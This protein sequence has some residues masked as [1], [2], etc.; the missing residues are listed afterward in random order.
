LL[1]LNINVYG[2]S[3]KLVYIFTDFLS[4]FKCLIAFLKPY[5]AKNCCSKAAGEQ[6][7]ILLNPFWGVYTEFR[8]L[9]KRQL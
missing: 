2:T 9:K 6:Q 8:R 1:K 4:C 3:G 7:T 5:E